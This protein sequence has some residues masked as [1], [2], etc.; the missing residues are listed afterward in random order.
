MTPHLARASDEME[1]RG[2]GQ[3][4]EVVVDGAVFRT[5]DDHKSLVGVELLVNV[6]ILHGQL[7]EVEVAVALAVE[8]IVHVYAS[9]AVVA[10]EDERVGVV[11]ILSVLV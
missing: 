9:L 6:V 11:A 2:L 4:R 8:A 10:V 3:W 5:V 7:V 1:V